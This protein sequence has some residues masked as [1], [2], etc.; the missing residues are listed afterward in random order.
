M[1]IRVV[2]Y[3]QCV[4]SAG[5]TGHTEQG[6]WIPPLGYCYLYMFTCSRLLDHLPNNDVGPNGDWSK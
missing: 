6:G 5:P 2:Q 1:Y 3:V 4:H